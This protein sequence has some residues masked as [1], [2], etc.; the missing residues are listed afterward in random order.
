MK[1]VMDHFSN[2]TVSIPSI[3]ISEKYKNEI[4]TKTIQLSLLN[5]VFKNKKTKDV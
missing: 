4:L 3:T 2:L 1:C 5:K